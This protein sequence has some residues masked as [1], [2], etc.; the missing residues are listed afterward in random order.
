MVVRTLLQNRLGLG[1]L[2]DFFAFS[3]VYSDSPAFC[4]PISPDPHLLII[5][6]LF[7]VSFV[8]INTPWFPLFIRSDCCAL[9]HMSSN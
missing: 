6:R 7:V 9:I 1:A 8:S 5:C 4:F 3:P 2:E